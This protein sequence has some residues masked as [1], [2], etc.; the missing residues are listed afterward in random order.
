M[1]III[2]GACGHIGSYLVQNLSKIKKL[3]KVILVDNL[4]KNNINSIFNLR[5][6][7]KISFFQIDLTKKNPLINFKKIDLIIHCASLTNASDSFNN[8]K[9]MY[10]N[11]LACMKN[12]INFCKKNKTKLLHISSTSVYGKQAKVVYE[13]DK[14]FLNPQS[15]YADIKLMEEKMLNKLK[16]KIKFVSFRFGTIAGISPGMRFH[17]AVNKFCLSASLGIGITVYKTAYNQ[18]RPYLSVRDAFKVFKFC[19]E[20]NFFNNNTYNALSGNYSVKQ[21]IET[22]KKY[23]K[24]VKIK[25]ISSPILNQ[26]SFLVSSEK[27]KKEKLFLNAKIERDIKQTLGIFKNIKNE[28]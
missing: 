4:K 14:R 15:P 21:I 6:K 1:N 24:K 23:K 13:D 7:P 11:N 19:I 17:T 20:H 27:L 16:N 18:Y 9:K 12:V 2:T 3:K 22:I 8:K 26:L 25:Y 5:S 28:M 10:Q